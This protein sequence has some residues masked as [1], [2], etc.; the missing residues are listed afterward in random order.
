MNEERLCRD[1]VRREE[2]SGALRAQG[3][4]PLGTQATREEREP[5]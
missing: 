1:E 3:P 5:K 2:R 4:L